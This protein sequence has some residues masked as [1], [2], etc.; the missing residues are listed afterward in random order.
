MISAV[1]AFCSFSTTNEPRK[2]APPVTITRFF[3]Q[4][5]LLLGQP[6]SIMF[7]GSSSFIPEIYNGNA[8]G[9][10][11]ITKLRW[12]AWITRRTRRPLTPSVRGA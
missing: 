1:P 5:S 4:N 3:C 7:K 8:T 11:F 2:P 9:S 6:L 12:A 10:P